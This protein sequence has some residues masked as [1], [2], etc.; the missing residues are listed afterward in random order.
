VG[1]KEKAMNTGIAAAAQTNNQPTARASLAQNFDT[2]L[3]LLTAQ[4]QNQDPLDP[5]DS[6]KFTD[7]LVQFSQVE[8]QIE[9]NDRMQ[10]LLDNQ[11]ASATGAAVGYIGRTAE[12]KGAVTALDSDGARWSYEL[13]RTAASVKL[14][15]LDG[16][17]RTVFETNR[18]GQGGKQSF[19]WDGRDIDGRERPHGN[20]R[21]KVEALGADGEAIDATIG[22]RER[23]TGVDIAAGEPT[24][25][26]PQGQ[27]TFGEILRILE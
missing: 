17:G 19:T 7:Q 3:T 15:V 27:R 21:L 26:T 4:L 12:V 11:T 18:V 9:T 16:A 14:S 22:V 6:S 13:D 2:F 23:I 8:Q 1:V 5:V 25:M 24:F 20:Y 10:R